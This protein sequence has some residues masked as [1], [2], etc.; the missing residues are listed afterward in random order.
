MAVAEGSVAVPA[1][2]EHP[3][4]VGPVGRLGRWAADHVRVVAIGWAVVAIALAVFAP[5]VETALSGA[6]W[7]A[8]GSQSVQAR[9]LIQKNFGGLASSAPIVVVHSSSLT[10]SSPAFRATIAKAEA[11][12]RSDSRIAT[13]MPPRPGVSISRDGHTALVVAGAKKDPTAMV[14]AADRLKGKLHKLA[15]NSVSVNLTGASG[16]WSDF[17][18]A[19][20]TAMMKSE[21]FSWPVTM[22][23][24]VLAFGSL[25]AAGLP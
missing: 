15:T 24:L 16:M 4:A 9:A 3:E 14:A 13:V 22:A 10:T 19:N 25:V 23:I 8:N 21:L 11:I 12:L 7:Q 17:N 5:K 2:A 18:T 1:L 20:R 6:G